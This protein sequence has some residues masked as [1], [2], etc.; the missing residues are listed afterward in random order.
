M[1]RSSAKPMDLPVDDPS[2]ERRTARPLRIACATLAVAMSSPLAASAEAAVS[3]FDDIC[4]SAPVSVSAQ[5]A[6]AEAR[7]AVRAP[8]DAVGTSQPGEVTDLFVKLQGSDVA[9]AMI[10]RDLQLD[11]TAARSCSLVWMPSSPVVHDELIETL[12][13]RFGEPATDADRYGFSFV[14]WHLTTNETTEW[15]ILQSDSEGTTLHSILPA[16]S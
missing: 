8:L 15:L 4:R 6:R 3:I 11:G 1:R 9:W 7:E 2:A 12:T 16:E 10:I 14:D 5:I 13:A